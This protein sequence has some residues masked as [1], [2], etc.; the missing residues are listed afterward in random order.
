MML[1]QGCPMSHSPVASQNCRDSN[2][3]FIRAVVLTIPSCPRPKVT[4]TPFHPLFMGLSRC[5]TCPPY[6]GVLL[7]TA[8][9]RGACVQPIRD[10]DTHVETP[11]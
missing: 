9:P 6:G 10:R 3:P 11:I 4:G 8:R 2:S 1:S 7:G 5:P